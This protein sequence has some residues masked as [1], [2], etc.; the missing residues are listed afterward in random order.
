MCEV[1][2]RKIE[3]GFPGEEMDKNNRS[4]NEGLAVEYESKGSAVKVT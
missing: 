4:L 1:T 2:F 3:M